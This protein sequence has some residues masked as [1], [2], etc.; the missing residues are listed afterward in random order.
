MLTSQKWSL[1]KNYKRQMP[2]SKQ[3]D[4]TNYDDLKKWPWILVQLQ[5]STVFYWLRIL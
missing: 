4:S 1:N 5:K 2:Q 3:K